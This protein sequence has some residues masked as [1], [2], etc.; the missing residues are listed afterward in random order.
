M[1]GDRDASILKTE[2]E[3]SLESAFATKNF[4]MKQNI[5]YK[6]PCMEKEC[7]YLLFILHLAEAGVLVRKLGRLSP[8]S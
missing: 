7:T 6:L 8:L 1:N 4:Y 3:S 2:Y 5:M